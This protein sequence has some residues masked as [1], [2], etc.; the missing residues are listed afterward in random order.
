MMYAVINPDG[1]YA[2]V[3]CESLDEAREMMAQKEGR[4][5]AELVPHTYPEDREEKT[6]P[7][8][9]CPYYDSSINQCL[10]VGDIAPCEEEDFVD[11]E[12]EEYFWNVEIW[13]ER[14]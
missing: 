12:E 5:I 8:L 14:V 1:T 6:V 13:E 10:Y 3:P 11:E 4:W 7:C 2:G 9:S